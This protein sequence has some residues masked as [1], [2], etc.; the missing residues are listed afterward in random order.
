MANAPLGDEMA[1]AGRTGLPDGE[2]EIF[3]AK[4]LDSFLLT[5]PSGAFREARWIRP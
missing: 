1:R 2:S 4:G 5:C 3:F